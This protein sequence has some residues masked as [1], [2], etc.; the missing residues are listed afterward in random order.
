MAGKAGRQR[1][2]RWMAGQIG[3]R[4]RAQH[5]VLPSAPVETD[6]EGWAIGYLAECGELC[7]RADDRYLATL[8]FCSLC[9]AKHPDPG[10]GRSEP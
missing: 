3:V 6:R 4:H 7:I 5:F 1:A 9:R 10:H 2:G 8:P